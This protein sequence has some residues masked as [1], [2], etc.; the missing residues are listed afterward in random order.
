MTTTKAVVV[1]PEAE[2]VAVMDVAIPELRDEWILVKVLAVALNPTDWKHIDYEQADV[3][4]R[5]GCDYAG[6]VEK[7][8]SKVNRFKKGDRIAGFAH[9]GNRLNRE[10]G[11]FGEYAHVKQCVQMIIPDNLSFEQAATL[12]VGTVTCR[13]GLYKSLGLP[14]PT[15]PA[16]T[17]FPVLIYGG[18]T[19]TGVLGIQFVKA[20]GLTAIATASPANFKYLKSIGADAVFDYR[21]PSCGADIRAFTQNTLKFAWDCAGGGEEICAAALSDSEP[22]A[23]GAI[24]IGNIDG[25]VL[26]KSNPLVDGP[27]ITIAYDAIGEGWV[28]RG[29]VAPPKVDEMDFANKFM[30]IARKLIEN[31]TIKP[32]KTTLNQ[33]G[34][35]LDG[36]IKELDELRAGR[37]SCTKLVYTL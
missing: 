1:Y 14:L 28:W 16:Q 20:S 21:S 33:G 35:G 5:I 6:V 25:E 7:V 9:G 12:G 8:G 17:P 26:K 15:E 30:E 4:C 18:S 19:A 10:S 3:G 11:A 29:Q 13:Q 23:Y 34:A 36:V 2:Q 22:S 37:V 32:I 24:N 27:L 31:E